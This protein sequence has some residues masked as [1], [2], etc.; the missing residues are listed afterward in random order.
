MWSALHFSFTNINW[1]PIMG[2]VP[3]WA[4]EIGADKADVV[5]IVELWREVERVPTQ[6]VA[7]N[8]NQMQ[9]GSHQET[10][11]QEKHVEIALKYIYGENVQYWDPWNHTIVSLETYCC[12]LSYIKREEFGLH[13]I[14]HDAH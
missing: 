3:R 12:T 7:I 1:E 14:D 11:S 13:L 2:Q 4:L 5:F 8:F 9:W 10:L 6:V